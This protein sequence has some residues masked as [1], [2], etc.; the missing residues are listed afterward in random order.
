[1]LDIVK[2][3]VRRF[4]FVYGFLG[5]DFEFFKVVDGCFIY[6]IQNLCCY[7]DGVIDFPSLCC[8]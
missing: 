7:Y 4:P 3:F 5:W 2:I 6:Y 8:Y 1:M